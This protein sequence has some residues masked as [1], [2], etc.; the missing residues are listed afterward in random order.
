Y[1]DSITVTTADGTTQLLTV[2]MIGTDDATVITGTASAEL[3]EAATAQTTGGTLVATDP[4]SSN[5]FEVQGDVAGTNGYGKF[6]IDANGVWS[7]TMDSAH[8]EFVAGQTYT[9][10]FT[11]KSVDGT[12]LSVAVNILG[13]NDVSQITGQASGSVTEDGNGITGGTLTV[14]DPDAGESVFM[15]AASAGIFG[16]FNFDSATGAWAYTLNNESTAVQSLPAGETLSETFTIS[17]ADG[18]SRM[19]TVTIVGINDGARIGTPDVTTVEEDANVDSANN[20]VA[21]GTISL[22]D[23]DAG[24]GAFLT[25]VGAAPGTLGQLQ[26]ATDGSYTYTVAN[27]AVQ[28]LAE[29]QVKVETFTITSLDGTTKE[30]SF[31][32]N[33]KN[34]VAGAI[35]DSY[36]TNRDQTL[37]VPVANS[38]LGNDSDVD[39]DTL[40]AALVS[41]PIHGAVSLN[42]DGSFTY[43]PDAGY[44][45]TDTFTYRA[46]DGKADSE[47]ATV[48]IDVRGV[49]KPDIALVTDTGP[50]GGDTVT[51]ESSLRFSD[52][53][54]GLTRLYRIN[55]GPATN[56]FILPQQDGTYTVQVIDSDNYGNSESSSLSFT[57]DM[58]GPDV[59]VAVGNPML[60]VGETTTL[61]F[62]FNEVPSGFELNDVSAS[63]GALG[64]LQAT[65]DPKVFTATYTP[66]LNTT[67]TVTI[68]VGDKT[69]TDAAGNEGSSAVAEL[70]VDTAVQLFI[71]VSPIVIVMPED[72]TTHISKSD[73]ALRITNSDEQGVSIPDSSMWFV[74]D[75]VPGIGV[76][77]LK[78]ANGNLNPITAGMRI[79]LDQISNLQFT[80]KQNEY[81]IR[82]DKLDFHVEYGDDPARM[83]STRNTEMWFSVRNVNDAP[84]GSA[85]PAVTLG[86]GQSMSMDLGSVFKDVDH[87]DAGRLTYTVSAAAG[88]TATISGSKL[89]VTN[90]NGEASP[91]ALT[92][93]AKD[94][95][96]AVGTT[97]MNVALAGADPLQNIAP[98]LTAPASISMSEGAKAGD[99]V[100]S[101]NGADTLAD[102][103]NGINETLSYS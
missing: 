48:T 71:D 91:V 54:P 14:S 27:G 64:P 8:D 85:I 24:Q 50:N 70:S 102:N 73:L 44:F 90:T 31:T 38:V 92:I 75:S 45:G 36:A 77:L 49:A 61:T 88:V 29:G 30:I 32:I 78:D 46:N 96:G 37:I 40:A 12:T 9:D 23:I 15:P 20:L 1:T 76:A 34:D 103:T 56:E 81:A 99:L 86:Q 67:A 65:S 39:G 51:R 79:S 94:R 74:I 101:V 10:T 95:S 52:P 47:T 83:T 58:S 6:S 89:T 19:I 84:I 35:S 18:T 42:S 68:T 59:G 3:T 100:F 4:D 25:T 82:Y 69:Y 26:L 5:A 7:Y 17:S 41:G 53:A 13:T 60:S 80:P 98:T 57:L 22:T 11:V 97:T 72:A 21:S 93:T 2:T 16:T 66:P 43:T 28:S 33:G 63:E 62:S 87:E 55:G